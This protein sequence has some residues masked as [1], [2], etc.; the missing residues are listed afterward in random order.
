MWGW[1]DD[2]SGEDGD[3]DCESNVTG[4][5]SGGPPSAD[6]R[7][8]TQG[9]LRRSVDSLTVEVKGISDQPPDARILQF[10]R[11]VKEAHPGRS[12][13]TLHA[14]DW[15]HDYPDIEQL[16]AAASEQGLI[17]AW[18]QRANGQD[19]EGRWY[20]W[21]VT[22][23]ARL[24]RVLKA[25]PCEVHRQITVNG[26]KIDIRSIVGKMLFTTSVANL[27]DAC[28]IWLADLK[29]ERKATARRKVR[30]LL[31]RAVGIR[32]EEL[33]AYDPQLKARVMQTLSECK[34]G[35]EREREGYGE[36]DRGK[37]IMREADAPV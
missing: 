15:I 25:R 4:G 19:S 23:N 21:D 32:G 30:I 27:S 11:D 6:R 2:E 35:Y 1:L 9:G 16:L 37:P 13:M 22:L 31:S 7:Q 36:E 14:V 20:F 18:P 26:E 5:G 8:R 24:I 34:V 17:D 29:N 12:E 3:V 10:L 28:R 33:E